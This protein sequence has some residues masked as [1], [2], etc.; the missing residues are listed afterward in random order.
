[1]QNT[2]FRTDRVTFLGQV[3]SRDGLRM[4]PNK[5][6]AIQNFPILRDLKM[7]GS[8]VGAASYYR[9]FI[10]FSSRIAE[11]LTR[12]TRKEMKFVKGN[13]QLDVIDKIKKT[14]YKFTCSCTLWQQATSWT[15]NWRE[16]LRTWCCFGACLRRR[17]QNS[18]ICQ[19]NSFPAEMNYHTTE[20]E[21]L[22]IIYALNKFRT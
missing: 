10:P 16:W 17:F 15:K 13:K 9:K 5:K 18:C 19:Q 8:S 20:K 14:H 7:L 1:M 3:C 4:C 22:A 21:C 6:S 11:P 2:S 12:L